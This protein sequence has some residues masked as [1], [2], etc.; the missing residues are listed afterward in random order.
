MIRM[1]YKIQE[2]N[3]RV[4]DVYLYLYY[5]CIVFVIFVTNCD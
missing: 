4:L 1:L 5:S 2:A 3:V